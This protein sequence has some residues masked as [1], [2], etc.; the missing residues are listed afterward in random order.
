MLQLKDTN[1]SWSINLLK[2]NENYDSIRINFEENPIKLELILGSNMIAFE[3]RDKEGSVF[4][5]SSFYIDEVM[6]GTEEK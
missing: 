6:K 4:H 2:Y 1:F 3:A 5:R